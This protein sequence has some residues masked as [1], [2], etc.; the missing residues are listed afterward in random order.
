MRVGQPLPTLSQE[1]HHRA[2]AGLQT[3]WQCWLQ[4]AACGTLLALQTFGTTWLQGLQAASSGCRGLNTLG[5]T[6]SRLEQQPMPT[7]HSMPFVAGHRVLVAGTPSAFHA[8][9]A[10]FCRL[11]SSASCAHLS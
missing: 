9:P 4:G 3:L 2:P 8:S 1:Q 7:R 10:Q 11:P 5:N 6:G